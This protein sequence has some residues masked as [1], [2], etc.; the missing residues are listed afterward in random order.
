M[1]YLQFQFTLSAYNKKKCIALL[2]ACYTWGKGWQNASQLQP[3]QQIT[4]SEIHN[5]ITK[6]LHEW[7]F[8]IE[9]YMENP[10]WNS[11]LQIH[12]RNWNNETRGNDLHYTYI[13]APR[14]RMF[15]KTLRQ[16]NMKLLTIPYFLHESIFYNFIEI[17]VQAIV[18]VAL[19]VQCTLVTVRTTCFQH[20]TSVSFTHSIVT[21]FA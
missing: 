8:Y 18:L 5:S 10:V 20:Q 21:L 7:Y 14:M 3:Y 9:S 15:V 13:H 2:H 17:S 6:T 1:T 12:V 19:T 4:E 11:V 16:S